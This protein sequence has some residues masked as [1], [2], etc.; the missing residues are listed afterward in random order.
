[1]TKTSK[2]TWDEIK[3]LKRENKQLKKFISESGKDNGEAVEMELH[4]DYSINGHVFELNGID[5]SRIEKPELFFIQKG[6]ADGRR[7]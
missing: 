5:H 2:P 4:R 6:F 3:A 1:M 7:Y